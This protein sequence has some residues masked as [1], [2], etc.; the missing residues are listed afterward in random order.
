MSHTEVRGHAKHRNVYLFLNLDVWCVCDTSGSQSHGRNVRQWGLPQG[1]RSIPRR[2][3]PGE[4][5]WFWVRVVPQPT[6]L[7][8]FTLLCERLGVIGPPLLRLSGAPGRS[9]R[10]VPFSRTVALSGGW[11]S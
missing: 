5:L 1:R 2:V 10:L 4:Y 9:S 6:R 7:G 3:C 8:V 11:G